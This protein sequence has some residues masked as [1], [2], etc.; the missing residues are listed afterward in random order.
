[1]CPGLS[2]SPR[3]TPPPSTVRR[4]P[5]RGPEDLLPVETRGEDH[6]LEAVR[7]LCATLD[8]DGLGDEGDAVLVLVVPE[9]VGFDEDET[10]AS[11]VEGVG[12]PM[13][14]FSLDSIRQEGD[15]SV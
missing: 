3:P 9:R 5:Q 8:D 12:S 6:V 14:S 10:L 7:A 1:M 11:R 2:P 4:R 13:L 15:K